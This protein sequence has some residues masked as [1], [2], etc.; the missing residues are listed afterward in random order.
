MMPKLTIA[1]TRAAL[2]W[3]AIGFTIGLGLLI[4]KATG[5]L[6]LGVG[7]L[8]AHLHV[9]LFGWLVQ[10]IFAVGYWMLPR[11]GRDRPRRGFAIAAIALLNIASCLAMCF[12]WLRLHEATWVAQG[13]GVICFAVHAW[14]RVKAFGV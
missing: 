12:P 8:H 7:W 6:G 9:L 14:P 10:L 4:D 1:A 2:A 13:F 5:G 3:F 11:F